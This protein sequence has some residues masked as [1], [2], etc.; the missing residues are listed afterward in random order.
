MS[1]L[2]PHE[3]CQN[4]DA[5]F[6]SFLI[7]SFPEAGIGKGNFCFLFYKNNLFVII[8]TLLRTE[9]VQIAHMKNV[10][11]GNKNQMITQSVQEGVEAEIF[12]D[13]PIEAKEFLIKFHNGVDEKKDIMQQLKLVR[14][15]PWR[16]LIYVVC[17]YLLLVEGPVILVEFC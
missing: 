5:S 14:K 15:E 13:M 10:Q 4:I 3:S 2:G 17:N 9:A 11:S 8:L 12:N 7:V 1:F 16:Q 6:V